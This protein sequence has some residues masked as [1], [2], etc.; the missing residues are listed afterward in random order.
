MCPD[1]SGFG[2]FRPHVFHGINDPHLKKIHRHQAEIPGGSDLG[3]SW[4]KCRATW[5]WLTS[6]VLIT[7]KEKLYIVSAV[8]AN[9]CQDVTV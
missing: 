4:A 1:V 8:P 3:T 6:Q 9:V 2:V 5:K 7:G